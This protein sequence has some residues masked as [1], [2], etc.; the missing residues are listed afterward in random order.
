MNLEGFTKDTIPAYEEFCN[1]YWDF[2]FDGTQPENGRC[3]KIIASKNQE[4]LGFI[5]YTSF[6]VKEGIAELDIWLKSL[7]YAGKGIGTEAINVLVAKL[8]DELGFHTFFMRPSLQNVRA[9][10]AYK[11]AGFE[12]NKLVAEDYYKPE[13]IEEYRKGGYGEG[14]D[15]FLVKK[16]Q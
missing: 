6:H 3:Y 13:F 9:V 7:D 8:A 10:N 4:E 5:Y 12:E 14:K 11:K 2:F 16:V 15:V 1:E